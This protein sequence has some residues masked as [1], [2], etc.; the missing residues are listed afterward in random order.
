ME[1]YV[2][3]V[4]WSK[5]MKYSSL[6]DHF[7]LVFTVCH[8]LHSLIILFDVIVVKLVV[9]CAKSVTVLCCLNI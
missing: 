9:Y 2:T 3:C 6:L 4:G 5:T 7:I 8:L 1:S